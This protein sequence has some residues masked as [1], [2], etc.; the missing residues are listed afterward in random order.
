MKVH[1]DNFE[2]NFDF[3]YFIRGKSVLPNLVL[4]YLNPRS[5]ILAKIHNGNQSF[6]VE[7]TRQ[8]LNHAI[9]KLI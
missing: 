1:V 2:R 6:L 5:E 3:I 8:E 9:F 7:T 4:N